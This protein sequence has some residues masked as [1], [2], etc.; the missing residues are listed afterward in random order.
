MVRTRSRVR[1]PT[2]AQVFTFLCFLCK[3]IL[4]SKT[5]KTQ[6]V[7]RS[8]GSLL[9]RIDEGEFS[10]ANL[11]HMSNVINALAERP[12]SVFV[13]M[14]MLDHPWPDSDRYLADT[15]G[16]RLLVLLEESLRTKKKGLISDLISCGISRDRIRIMFSEDVGLEKFVESRECRVVLYSSGVPRDV[17]KDLPLETSS[18]MK[19][20]RL[21]DIKR[22]LAELSKKLG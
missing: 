18:R 4:K 8:I 11:S 1:F 14:D 21:P 20:L 3:V 19:S 5:M 9:K 13:M 10:Q 15:K 7:L 12:G 16:G 6:G 22:A 2:M 17:V